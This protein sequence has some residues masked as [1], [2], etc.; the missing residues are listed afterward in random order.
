MRPDRSATYNGR[1]EGRSHYQ[2]FA[3]GR[4]IGINSARSLKSTGQSA[5]YFT[6]NAGVDRF[7]IS[8]TL[9]LRLT[10]QRQSLAPATLV[11]GTHATG[12]SAQFTTTPEHWLKAYAPG[13]IAVQ[14][15]N[16]N[17]PFGSAAVGAVVGTDIIEQQSTASSQTGGI[18]GGGG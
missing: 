11:D 5:N 12:V 15:S 10:L 17:T 18:V 14:P 16:R 13:L 6:V 9:M 7:T 2:G 8:G 4:T 3:S 1:T